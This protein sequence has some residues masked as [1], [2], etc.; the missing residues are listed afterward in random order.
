MNIPKTW[1][2]WLIHHAD[3]EALDKN[4]NL[5]MGAAHQA[6]TA[7]KYIE[8]LHE[9]NGLVMMTKPA[10]GRRLQFSF[11]HHYHGSFLLSQ[12][13]SLI[14][15]PLSRLRLNISINHPTRE[16]LPSLTTLLRRTIQQL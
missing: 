3:A 6:N 2:E 4:T 7:D 16:T 8:L 14:A 1:S 13:K 15:I 10:M 11:Q 12:Q 5:V 9:N